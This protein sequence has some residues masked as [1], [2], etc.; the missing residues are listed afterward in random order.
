LLGRQFDEF[1]TAGQRGVI[2]SLG[3]RVPRLLAP[4]P[5][6]C[7]GVVPGILQVIGA[8]V[9]GSGFGASSEEIGLKLALLAFELFDLLLQRGDAVE[10]IAMARLPI[11]DLLTESEILALQAMDSSA[12][13][14]NFPA[15][16]LHQS[17]QIRG[18]VAR[19]NGTGA[20]RDGRSRADGTE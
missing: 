7:P 2:A 4:V 3:T 5:L 15:H 20:L 1:L 9:A 19:A 11:S 10:G 14:A 13:L 18:G 16:V 12:E 8:I 6:G 17:D